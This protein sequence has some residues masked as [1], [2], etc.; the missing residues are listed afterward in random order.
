MGSWDKFGTQKRRYQRSKPLSKE[1]RRLELVAQSCG[2][3]LTPEQRRELNS[4]QSQVSH[5]SDSGVVRGIEAAS[6]RRPAK[7]KAFAFADVHAY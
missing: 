3:G 2:P 5:V 1:G 6:S 4:L 7:K